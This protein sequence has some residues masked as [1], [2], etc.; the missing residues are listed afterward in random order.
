MK[1]A[2]E[3]HSD[4]GKYFKNILSMM[5]KLQLNVLITHGR[6]LLIGISVMFLVVPHGPR[7]GKHGDLIKGKTVFISCSDHGLLLFSRVKLVSRNENLL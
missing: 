6:R 5:A 1:S 3:Y 4:A 7:H 2:I